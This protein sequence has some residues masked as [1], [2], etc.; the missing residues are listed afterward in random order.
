MNR[1]QLQVWQVQTKMPK[2]LLTTALLIWSSLTLSASAATPS[3]TWAYLL[4]S[5]IFLGLLVSGIRQRKSYGYFF[6]TLFLWMGFWLK[7]TAH[8]LLDYAFLE[9]VGN[10]YGAGYGWY[11]S[12][13]IAPVSYSL[14]EKLAWDEVLGVSTCSATGLLLAFAIFSARHK[15]RATAD[16]GCDLTPVWYPE[17][18]RWLWPSVLT[19]ITCAAILNVVLGVQQAGLL[20]RT[21][22][23]WPLNALLAWIVSMGAAIAVATL[24]HWDMRTNRSLALPLCAILFEGLLSTVSLLSRAAYIFHVLPQLL[25]LI[26]RRTEIKGFT[27]RRAA[28]GA[29]AVV[30]LLLVSIAAVTGLRSQLYWHV[31]RSQPVAAWQ[32]L[33]PPSAPAEAPIRESLSPEQQIVGEGIA[34]LHQRIQS[35]QAMQRQL[36]KL[37]EEQLRL[38]IGSSLPTAGTQLS[39]RLLDATKSA[40]RVILQLATDRWIGIE[41]VMAVQAYPFK[42][43]SAFLEALTEK[44]EIGKLTSYQKIS[45]SL[46]AQMD[47]ARSQFASLPGATALFLISGSLWIVSAGMF[48]LG[49][50]LLATERMILRL[51][52][53]PLLCALIGLAMANTIAQMGVAPRQDLPYYLMIFAAVIAVY[54]LQTQLF[55]SLLSWLGLHRG[56]R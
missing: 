49:L 8:I 18:R 42:G 53:N 2:A 55:A 36:N 23:A 14:G 25:A 32:P 26:D 12:S 40:F 10:F 24:V 13:W 47:N 4:F 3:S 1:R 45:N 56:G 9:P 41:G 27:S 6:L 34:E 5:I 30:V 33:P 51:T 29:A 7:Y 48:V 50:A 21:V 22:L 52:A 20:P 35:G 15:S 39:A 46:Y 38:K 16:T 44:R 54:S 43:T 28:L 37:L 17:T 31:S 19:A 11:R